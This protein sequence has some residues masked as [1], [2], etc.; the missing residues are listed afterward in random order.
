MVNSKRKGKCGE[1]ELAKELTRLGLSARRGRQYHGLEGKDVVLDVSG[2]HV[3]CKRVDRL[4][5]MKAV[6]QACDDAGDGE[7]PIVCSRANLQPWLVTVKLDDLP[8]LVEVLH[9]HLLSEGKTGD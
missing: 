4:Q 9:L 8:R 6:D 1:L 7:V 2:V 5:L 3:E